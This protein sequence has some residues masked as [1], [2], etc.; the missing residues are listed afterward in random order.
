MNFKDVKFLIILIKTIYNFLHM[1]YIMARDTEL[2][3]WPFID[4]EMT[5]VLILI[6]NV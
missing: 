5:P 4:D 6:G 2:I 3:I 1:D